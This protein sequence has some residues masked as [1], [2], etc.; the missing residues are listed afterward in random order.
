MARPELDPS[1]STEPAGMPADIETSLG[2]A[3]FGSRGDDNIGVL[4]LTDDT[5]LGAM[6]PPSTSFPTREDASDGTP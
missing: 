1:D 2:A 5:L 6:R 4:R 3:H